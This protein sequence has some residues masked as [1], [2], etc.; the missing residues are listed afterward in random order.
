MRFILTASV[1]LTAIAAATVGAQ[2]QAPATPPP[3]TPYF[4]GNPLG[5]PSNPAPDGAFNPISPNVKVYGSL[6]QTESCSYDPD[7]DLI[8]APNRGVGQADRPND[9]YIS[10]IN[11]DGSVHTARWVGVQNPGAQRDNMDP[12][13]VLNQPFGSDIVDGVLYLAD[14]DGGLRD[15]AGGPNTPSVSVIR[16]FNMADGTIAGEIRT[17]GSG[18]FNDL[19]VADDTTIYASNS[20]AANNPD[21]WQIWKVTPDGQSA[22]WIQGP[23]LNRP[24]GV[25]IDNDGNVVVVNQG[26]DKVLTF[27]AADASLMLTETASQAGLDGIV[28]MEDGTK[29]VSSVGNGGIMRIPPGGASELIAENVPSAASMCYDPTSNMLVVPLNA[30][31][32]LAFVPLN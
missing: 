4:V 24:N 14:R 21:S 7:R 5:L 17:E 10:F 9:A 20:G 32:G 2:A 1:A 28:I 8:V 27:S 6:Y 18:G 26:D 30:H 13:L 23:P 19:E 12:P 31:S 25:A 16:K 11:H 3:P 29:Y 15:P 22:V